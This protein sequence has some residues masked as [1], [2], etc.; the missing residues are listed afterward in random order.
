MELCFCSTTKYGEGSC[1]KCPC[2][3]TKSV[4]TDNVLQNSNISYGKFILL[5]NAFAESVPIS[6]A[7]EIIKLSENAIRHFYQTICEQIAA[8][9]QTSRKI[10]RPGKIVEV[11]EAK[12][13]K[14]K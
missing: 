2:G 11:D 9:V 12:F 7:A 1:W 6:R 3:Q 13:G 10:S 5:F 4:R 14:R 8:N